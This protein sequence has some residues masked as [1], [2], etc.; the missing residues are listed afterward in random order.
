MTVMLLTGGC[1]KDLSGL[2]SY[3]PPLQSDDG[4]FTGTL[5][6]VGMD[7]QVMANCMGHIYSNKYDQVHSLLI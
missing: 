2:Y 4:I 1:E 7:T 3:H 6:Q 5:D